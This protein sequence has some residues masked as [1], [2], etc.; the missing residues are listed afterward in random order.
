MNNEYT[1]IVTNK[2]MIHEYRRLSVNP[3]TKSMIVN[4]ILIERLKKSES[5][6]GYTLESENFNKL[7]QSKSSVLYRDKTGFQTAKLTD[8]Q[9]EF[10]NK[11]IAEEIEYFAVKSES[12]KLYEFILID[13][14]DK[15]DIKEPIIYRK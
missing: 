11:L 7:I 5:W 3:I 13:K 8:S 9:V 2:N 14:R 6:Y 4:N 10:V 1:G 15:N 12:D